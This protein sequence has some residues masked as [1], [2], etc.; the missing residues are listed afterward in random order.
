MKASVVA[1]L[2]FAL[3]ASADCDFY[4]KC[5]CTNSDGTAAPNDIQDQACLQYSADTKG[6]SGDGP[7]NMTPTLDGTVSWCVGNVV[8]AGT[9]FHLDN[10]EYAKECSAK[11]APGTPVCDGIFN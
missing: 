10:C 11:G 1:S 9:I 7:G 8:E 3:A 2:F 5:Y 6:S 4:N